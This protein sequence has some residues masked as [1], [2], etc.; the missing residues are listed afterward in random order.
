MRVIHVVPMFDAIVHDTS[1]DQPT[2]VCTPDVKATQHADGTTDYVLTHH[3]M[4]D[5][6]QAGA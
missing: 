6:E 2:C 1:S 4:T 5:Q 3:D